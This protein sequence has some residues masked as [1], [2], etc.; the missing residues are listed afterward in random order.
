MT[1]DLAVAGLSCGHCVRAVEHAIAARDPAARVQ[2]DLAAGRVRI[3][4]RLSRAEAEAAIR[5]AG[6]EPRDA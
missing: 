3:E 2:V 6:Y 4:G 1:L 5:D